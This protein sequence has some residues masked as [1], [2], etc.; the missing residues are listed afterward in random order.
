MLDDSLKNEIDEKVDIY[1]FGC[2]LYE[3][4]ELEKLFI[5]KSREKNIT[6]LLDCRLFKIN[7]KFGYQ[8]IKYFLFSFI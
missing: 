1:A 7:E 4:S 6:K 5:G 8:F 2:L 3:M